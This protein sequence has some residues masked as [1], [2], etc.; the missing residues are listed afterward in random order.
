MSDNADRSYGP[1]RMFLLCPLCGRELID[2]WKLPS[3][4]WDCRCGE[5]I[6]AKL[7]VDP[8]A[9]CTCGLSCNCGRELRR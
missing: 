2:E 6:P 9:G 1:E 7:V 3:G 4:G 8:F 5:R